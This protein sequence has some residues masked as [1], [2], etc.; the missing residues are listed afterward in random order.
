MRAMT[1]H[2]YPRLPID[3]LRRARVAARIGRT[4]E[5]FESVDSTNSVAYR[6]A[7]D[8]AAYITGAE[9]VIDGGYTAI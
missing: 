1:A 7:S 6:L 8:G 3:E 5:Y 2:A 9:I 4:I